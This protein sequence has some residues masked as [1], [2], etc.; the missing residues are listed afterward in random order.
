MGKA[1]RKQK[2]GGVPENLA[3]KLVIHYMGDVSDAQGTDVINRVLASP[4][5][6]TI[7]EK[8]LSLIPHEERVEFSE[9]LFD[10]ACR[11]SGYSLQQKDGSRT[12][13]Q[14]CVFGISVRGPLSHIERLIGPEG[15]GRFTKLLRASGVSH[16]RSNV[17]LC[18]VAIDMVSASDMM[19]PNLREMAQSLLF[20]LVDQ[21][22]G[23]HATKTLQGMLLPSQQTVPQNSVL[24][25]NRILL[26]AR[27]VF[28][29]A[30]GEFPEDNF[31]VLKPTDDEVADDQVLD[32]FLDASDDAE[33][34]FVDLAIEMCQ[35]M[36]LTLEIASPMIWTEALGE[37]A[38]A[39]LRGDLMLEAAME[40]KTL[41]PETKLHLYEDD[42]E[43]SFN[44]V[45]VDG[46]DIYGPVKV[47]LI[48]VNYGIR[49][50]TDWMTREFEDII[51]HQTADTLPS[52]RR[53]R[54]AN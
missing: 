33:A 45:A 53:R 52:A 10:E 38:L 27:M 23:F 28:Q 17:I 16:D 8:A 39:R 1:R 47:P 11:L 46:D 35:E 54:L 43:G 6:M 44:L 7:L 12:P 25:V 29:E 50:V 37:I 4:R 48:M 42:E 2:F 21:D 19:P 30:S 24:V 51:S 20:P 22:R 40:G 14:S 18:P 15:V 13:M 31:S 49:S 9:F 36:G 41:S 26:G 34:R 3:E 5:S 32:D